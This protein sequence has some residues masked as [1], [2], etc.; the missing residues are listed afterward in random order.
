MYGLV[1][2]D[3]DQ[4]LEEP[5]RATLDTLTR[6]LESSPR[7][8]V[9]AHEVRTA[10]REQNRQRSAARIAALRDALR[11]RG[12]DVSRLELIAAGSERDKTYL[13]STVQREMVSRVDVEVSSP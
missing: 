2:D 8:R 11:K 7:L 13:V 5:S 4:L 9:V 3:R 12:I 6:L 1:F 10:D